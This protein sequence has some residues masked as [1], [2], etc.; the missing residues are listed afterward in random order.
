MTSWSIAFSPLLPLR[1]LY[2]LAGA[3]L[4]RRRARSVRRARGAWLRALAFGLALLGLCDPASR[5][6]EPPPAQGYRR[7][8]RRPLGEPEHRRPAGA[9]PTRRATRSRRASRR[10]ATSTCASSK[11]RA[12]SPT[13]KARG[14]SPPCA[15]R[16]PTRP[17]ERVGGAIMITD[18]DVHDI[19]G[20]AAALG[21][22]APLHALITGHE[23]ERQRRIEL[24]EAPRYG[25]VGKDQTIAARVLDS[26]D[27]GEPVR[28]TVRRDGETIAHDRRRCRPA[29]R[30]QGADRARR[31]Q[32]DRARDRAGRRTN[33]RPMATAPSSTSTACATSCACCSSRASRIPGER[34]WRNLLKSDANVDLVHFT[35]LRPPEKGGDGM[36]IN[37]LSLI[38]FPVADLFG[39]KIKDFDLIIFDRYAQQAILPHVYLENIVNYVRNGG[40]LLMAEGPEYATPGR[41]VLLAAR[42][43]RARRADRRGPRGAVPGRDFARDGCAA[44]RHA[45]ARRRRGRRRRRPGAAGSASSARRRPNGRR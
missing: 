15:T 26:A 25:I 24:I 34:M 29:D 33:W 6:G 45:R 3:A 10:S 28:L 32:C 43:D 9:R 17:P 5:A 4:A 11:P 14:C 41:T 7:G 27:H 18:G 40:A 31:R 8:R 19:P 16:S 22:D 44:S 35:I 36:P 39:R 1:V 37:E 30:R 20:S 21:F 23:G 13:P 38:A 12:R 42:R 2:A